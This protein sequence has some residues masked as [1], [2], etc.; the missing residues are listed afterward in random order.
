[1]QPVDSV[2]SNSYK[3]PTM[4]MATTTTETQ[5]DPTAYFDSLEKQLESSNPGVLTMLEVFGDYDSAVQQA[6]AYLAAIEPRPVFLTTDRS[7]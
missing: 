6:N 5:K 1:M 2:E 7:N 4:S 3:S